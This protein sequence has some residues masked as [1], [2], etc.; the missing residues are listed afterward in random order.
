[1]GVIFE[2]FMTVNI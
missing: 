1:M 2:G